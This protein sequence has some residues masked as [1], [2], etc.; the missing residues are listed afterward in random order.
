MVAGWQY[1]VSNFIIRQKCKLS[2]RNRKRCEDF[3]CWLRDKHN[4]VFEG[5]TPCKVVSKRYWREYEDDRYYDI[6]FMETRNIF[7]GKK[8]IAQRIGQ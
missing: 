3:F 7:N 2:W 5:I 4:I 1:R 8:V 6:I